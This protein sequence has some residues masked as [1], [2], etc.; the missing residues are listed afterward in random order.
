MT[1][2]INPSDSTLHALPCKYCIVNR[3][4]WKLRDHFGACERHWIDLDLPEGRY[5]LW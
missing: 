3:K 2:S 5:P 4:T 1:A